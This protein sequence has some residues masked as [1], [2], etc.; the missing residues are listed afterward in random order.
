MARF[1]VGQRVRL[2]R[3]AHPENLGKELR[4]AGFFPE[5]DGRSYRVNCE[6][7]GTPEGFTPYTHTSRLEPILPDGHRAGDFTNIH[8]LLESISKEVA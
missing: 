6:V 5:R 8:D 1:F 2:V 7:L 4:I 3:P